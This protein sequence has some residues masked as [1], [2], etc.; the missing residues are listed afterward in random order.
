MKNR[1]LLVTLLGLLPLAST[2]AQDPVSNSVVKIHVTNREPDFSRPWAK[3]SPKQISGSGVIIDG[4]RILTNAHVVNYAIRILVQG[5]QATERIPASVLAVSPEMDLAL[6]ELDNDDFFSERPALELDAALPK[7]KDTISAYGYPI[8]GEQLSVTEGIVSRVEFS[9]YNFGSMGMRIQ[10]DAGLNPGNSGGPA[11]REGKIAGIVYSTIR[12]AENIGYVI[13][14]DEVRLFLED[15]ADETYDGKPNL[16]GFLQTVEN[17]T[18]RKRLGL[19]AADGGLMV[20]DPINDAEDYPL[21][22][23]DVITHVGEHPLDNKGNVQLEDGLKISFRY[24]MTDLVKENLLPVTILREGE[25]QQIQ[26]PVVTDIPV[27][28][29]NL[30]GAYPRHFIFG[31]LVFT[32][33]SQDLLAR[34][35]PQNHLV[36]KA[37]KNPLILRQFSR[38]DFPGEELVIFSV[39]MFPHPLVEG[40]DQQSFAAI[41]RINEVDIKNLLHLVETIRDSEGD[42]LTIEFH[43]LYET[44][45]LPRQEMFDSTDQ[46][47]E[48]EGIRTPYSDDLRETWENRKK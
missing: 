42:Y 45:V 47:L 33:A 22:P 6:L 34:I 16:V 23:W 7:A 44:M 8:G 41:H 3:G 25:T 15:I 20:R 14:A 39:R 19:E 9:R 37:R 31:P 28:V 21:K 46:I 30:K 11:I 38:P 13:P 43:G 1:L 18:L 40:Y 35:N 5:H 2:S 29:P 10:I 12:S 27:L 36:L 24:L 4:Q 32:A 17:P 26:L 48:D